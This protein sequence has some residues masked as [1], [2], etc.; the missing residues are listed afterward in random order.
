MADEVKDEVCGHKFEVTGTQ[1]S[2]YWV[3]VVKTCKKCGEESAALLA[4]ELYGK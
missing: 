1:V 4:K 3:R 2:A